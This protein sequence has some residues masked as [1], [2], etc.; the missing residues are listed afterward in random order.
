MK[1]QHKTKAQLIGELAEL[2][3]RIAELEATETERKRVEEGGAA[4]ERG[5]V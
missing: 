2:R 3:Q 5:A 1:D 4:R